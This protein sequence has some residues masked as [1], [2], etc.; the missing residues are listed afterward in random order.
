MTAETLT[1]LIF[2]AGL[3]QFGILTASALVPIR[4][5]WRHEL[6]ALPRLQRQMYWVYGGY[7]VLSI[8]AFGLISTFNAAELAAGGGLAR[9][10]CGYVAVFWGIRLSLQWVFDVEEH[11]TAWWLRWGER[12]LTVMFTLF[13]IVYAWGAL[14]P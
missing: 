14:R 10:F 12:T 5:N 3:A 2:V 13:T 7:V 8:I 1:M 9:A 6:Q 4:L 11:L